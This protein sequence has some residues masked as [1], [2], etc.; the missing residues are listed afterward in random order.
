MN[1]GLMGRHGGAERR[2]VTV[3]VAVDVASALSSCLS[4]FGDA[5]RRQQ[6]ALIC[7]RHVIS[8]TRIKAMFTSAA[9][10]FLMQSNF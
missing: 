1:N 8:V 6:P 2:T 7:G 3:V 4:R 5:W 10:P 9:W